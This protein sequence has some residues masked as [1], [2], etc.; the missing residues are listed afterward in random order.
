MSLCFGRCKEMPRGGGSRRARRRT[1]WLIVGS[2]AGRSGEFTIEDAEGGETLPVFGFEDEA[3]L[4]LRLE[5]LGEGW[6]AR[7]TTA[8]ELI[9]V[10]LRAGPGRVALDPWSSAGRRR[11][12]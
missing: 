8:G 1:Y 7:E 4:Y 2:G 9:C 11:A 3:L 5:E 10:L 12:S 6:R